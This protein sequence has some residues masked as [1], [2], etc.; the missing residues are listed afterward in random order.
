MSSDRRKELLKKITGLK[1]HRQLSFIE[2]TANMSPWS[3]EVFD[4][5]RARLRVDELSDGSQAK[6]AYDVFIENPDDEVARL[7]VSV[8][9]HSWRPVGITI[10]AKLVEV[11]QMRDN[12]DVIKAIKKAATIGTKKFKEEYPAFENAASVPPKLILETILE[13]DHGIILPVKQTDTTK[14][15]DGLR[16][17]EDD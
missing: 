8:D 15:Y 3:F 4:A 9:L 5:F 16:E 6:D 7:L 13:N 17:E 2:F 10:F 12:D 14:V 1:S 11:H